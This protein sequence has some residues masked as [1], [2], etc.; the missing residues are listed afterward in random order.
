MLRLT[1]AAGV[2]TV[3][4][5]LV[6]ANQTLGGDQLLEQ[7]RERMEAGPCHFH[8]LVPATPVDQDPTKGEPRTSAVVSEPGLGSERGVG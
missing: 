6:V 4:R 2:R 1:A 7:L 3:R 5:Y 8:V